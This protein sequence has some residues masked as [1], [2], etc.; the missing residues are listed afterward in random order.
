M[1]LLLFFIFLKKNKP[2][3]CFP[4]KWHK[5]KRQKNKSDSV[6]ELANAPAVHPRDPGCNC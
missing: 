1:K 4:L 2:S 3:F 6:A 5:Q